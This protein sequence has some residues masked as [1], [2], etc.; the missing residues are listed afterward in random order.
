[1]GLLGASMSYGYDL[2]GNLTTVADGGGTTNYTYDDRN[3]LTSMNDPNGIVW[4]FA[5]NADAQRTTTWFNTNSANT[6]WSGKLATSY[7]HNHRISQIQATANSASPATIS[8]TSYCYSPYASGQ[9]CPTASASTDT[10]LVQY[11]TG[12]KTST[13]S[14]YTYDPG[15]RLTKATNI[16]GK[17]YSYG[18]DTDGNLTSGAAAGSL[19][20][21][22]GNQISTSGYG[23]GYGYDG[24]GNLTSDPAN[25]TL[26]Y[27]DAGQLATAGNAGGHGSE[28]FT[29]TGDTQ[30]QVLSDGAASGITYGLAGQ[31]GQPWAESYT[32]ASSGSAVYVL[33]DQ[34]GTPLGYV[35]N[36]SSYM[37]ITDNLG[38]VTAVVGTCGCTDAT[39]TYDPYGH[40]TSQSG[41]QATTNLLGYTGALTD[42]AAPATTG[43]PHLGNRWYKPST[44]AFTSQDTS[45]YLASPANGNRY[46][47]AGDNP[48]NYV[49][50]AGTSFW[51]DLS[52]FAWEAATMAFNCVVGAGAAESAAAPA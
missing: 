28:T 50:P 47:Y 32:P 42:T 7:D 4:Q 30:N 46:A 15:N 35:Q 45:S 3:L 2:D 12:N 13:V 51:S 29:Y 49:D 24:A 16:G 43:Y 26:T 33:H 5:Y 39:Y 20:Y 19:S 6:T 44:G 9:A 31:D 38:S 23:D 10:S 41:S 52:S 48:V 34:Q 14:Q 18:Y 36:G 1:M 37:L 21:N 40:Q 11:A 27:N 25:G 22:S 17:T 8:D